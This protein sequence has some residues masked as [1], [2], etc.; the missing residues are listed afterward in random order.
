MA[1]PISRQE[2][3]RRFRA[4]GWEGPFAGGKHS[5]MAKGS[6]K[7]R[8]PNAHRGDTDWSLTKRILDQ[9]GVTPE[10]WESAG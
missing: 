7:V 2:L 8:I 1:K 10:E 9:A 4:L 5:F 6:R 3:I